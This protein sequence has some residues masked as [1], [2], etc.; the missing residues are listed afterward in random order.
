[1]VAPIPLLPPGAAFPAEL[2]PALLD[3]SLA[4]VLLLRPVYT[5]GGGKPADFAVEYLSPAAQRNWGQPER[6]GGTLLKYFPHLPASGV[7]D[8]YRQV[9]ETDTPGR[10]EVHSQTNGFDSYFYVAARR[11]GPWLLVSFTDTAEQPRGAL[12]KALR[13]SQAR[14]WAAGATAEAQRQRLLGLI[15]Q[16]P[17]VIAL[18]QGP[19][20][21]IELA[22]E[23]FR[24]AFGHRPL[25]GRTYRA[26]APELADQHLFEHL[27]AVYRTGEAFRA[28]EMLVHL[29]QTNSGQ[30]DPFYYNFVYQATRE[31]TGEVSG[32]LIIA[33]DVTALVLA[34]Q[35]VQ[36]LNEELRLSNAELEHQ[37][38]DRTHALLVTLQQLERRG[39]ELTQALAAEQALGELKSRFVSMASHEFRTP[40]T[41]VLTSADLIAEYP[42]ADQQP[43]RLR[44]VAH[45][46]TAVEH[47]ND[48]LEEFLSADR[49]EEGKLVAHP[50]NCDP[51]ALLVET[52]AA[53]Q[54]LRKAGQ[55]IVVQAYDGAIRLDDS[56]L[57]KILLN[58]LSNALKYSGENA[59]VTVAMECRNNELLLKVQD[60]G[61]GIS[62]ADQEHLF[63]RFFR[64]HNATELP[65]TGLGLFIIAKYLEL[66]DGHIA[67]HSELGVGTT[68]T[69]TIPYADHSAD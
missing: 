31:A 46:R 19:T 32:V 42:A 47:L 22:N 48:L 62:P 34:R 60:Q 25:V 26:A 3:V 41:V 56:L 55:T 61:I 38:T 29:D 13:E 36:A 2:L 69:V 6:P 8:F 18:L 63:E 54:G 21:V 66:M 51:A 43:D 4:A 35:R 40:L 52:V 37:V 58:L 65:G 7:L 39:R 53:V 12:E 59:V 28:S 10:Y 45:I 27:D 57:R 14:E 9:F 68:F 20:H 1:M 49:L 11:Q 23:G 33:T 44:H 17:V 64:A 67:L 30:L 24:R 50:A 5:P 16:A 15:G